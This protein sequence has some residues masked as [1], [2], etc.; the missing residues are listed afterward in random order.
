LMGMSKIQMGVA[1]ALA[2]AGAAGYLAQAENQAG[3]RREI[4]ALR[5]EPQAIA[6]LREENAQLAG[7][8]AEV[9]RLRA[10]DSEFARLSRLVAEAQAA[11][12]SR[13][14]KARLAPAPSTA[15]DHVRAEIERLNREGN[16]LVEEFKVLSEAAKAPSLLPEAKAAAQAAAQ[17]KLEAMKLKQAEIKAFT[18]NAR[19]AG[20]APPSSGKFKAVPHPG[21]RPP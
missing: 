3:L 10:D 4:A 13:N 14:E 9:E 6:L 1:G 16:K 19:A 12:R 18:D 15:P 17:Q 21:A 8:A 7:V 2:V 11:Q 20:W 5:A